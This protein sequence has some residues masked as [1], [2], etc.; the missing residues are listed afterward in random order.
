[1]GDLPSGTRVSNL[2]LWRGAYV[3][4]PSTCL[5]SGAL[6]RPEPTLTGSRGRAEWAA[7][8]IGNAGSWSTGRRR[9]G[10]TAHRQT[11]I[12]AKEP[13]ARTHIF[14]KHLQSGVL[15][16]SRM[17]LRL[18]DS[19][20][21]YSAVLVYRPRWISQDPGVEDWEKMRHFGSALVLSILISLSLVTSPAH[22]APQ[23]RFTAPV[24]TTSVWID[25]EQSSVPLEN[26]RVQIRQ[27]AVAMSKAGFGWTA[28]AP[29]GAGELTM[30]ITAHAPADA[31]LALTFT[32][33]DGG[34]LDEHRTPVQIL[35]DGPAPPTTTSPSVTPPPTSVPSKH[36][37]K[38][39]H[40]GVSSS[41]P[42]LGGPASDKPTRGDTS[43][44]SGHGIHS[45]SHPAPEANVSP[46]LA[47]SPRRHRGGL[48]DTGLSIEEASVGA[49]FL[50][51]VVG[52]AVGLLVR[53]RKR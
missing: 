5:P 44:E 27:Q 42:S 33:S 45:S 26:L 49:L 38:P 23:L 18:V 32:D 34:I 6:S 1:M 9:L 30:E 48:A 11:V 12:G 14:G 46:S 20:R 47:P 25:L 28:S 39:G 3:S 31:V 15:S 24:N 50:V 13:R 35:P 51:G 40:D 53:R 7:F 29:L 43:D 37:S 8:R 10:L 52:V 4:T 17:S 16:K 21:R 22:A 41:K 36:P 19:I 2:Q